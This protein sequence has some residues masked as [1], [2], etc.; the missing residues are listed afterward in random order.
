[1]TYRVFWVSGE[2]R[3]KGGSRALR[4]VASGRGAPEVASY[5]GAGGAWTR[6]GKS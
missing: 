3:Y 6:K 1:L 5:P 2:V 4:A